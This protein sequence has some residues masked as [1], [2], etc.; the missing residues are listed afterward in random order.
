MCSTPRMVLSVSSRL[1]IA[2]V[3]TALSG[4]GGVAVY[5]GPP[6][7]YL[8]PANAPLFAARRVL[9]IRPLDS[10]GLGLAYRLTT[11]LSVERTSVALLAEENLGAEALVP[12][13]IVVRVEAEVSEGVFE[14]FRTDGS[15]SSR[16]WGRAHVDVT[17]YDGPTGTE[18]QHFEYNER[19]RAITEA[20]QKV[21]QQLFVEVAPTE[22]TI[23]SSIPMLR[24]HGLDQAEGHMLAGR[25]GAAAQ[26]LETH[27]SDAFNS[28]EDE[29]VFYFAL[30]SCHR[31]AAVSASE[32]VEGAFQRAI[33]SFERAVLLQPDSIL[34][35]NAL[36]S[37]RTNVVE[38]ETLE[39][40]LA[41]WRQNQ[42]A[43]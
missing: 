43:R 5:A 23:A 30:G 28:P 37:T 12:G 25:W 11:R 21:E 16:P 17:T 13:T 38:R 9:V 15:S 14:N 20:I 42:V 32:D 41:S 24:I 2:F 35:I 7:S 18:L 1:L 34:Y 10:H 39:S 29:A 31:F 6:V 22:A 33:E 40:Q 4:C 8:R 36:S 3:I 27:T 26:H 19:G